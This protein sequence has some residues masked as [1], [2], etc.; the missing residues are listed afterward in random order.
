MAK[1]LMVIANTN[2]R[3]EELFHTKE[4]LEKAGHQTV[5]ASNSFS[6]A[7]GM[8][9][10]KIM[11]QILFKDANA[12]DYDAVVFVGGG[13]S[14][15]YFDN[16]KAHALA[17]E[18]FNQGKVTAAIC[19]A[20]STLANAGILKGKKATCYPS[21]KENLSAKGAKYT[22]TGVET[23]GKIITADGP[24]SAHEFGKKIAAA[25]K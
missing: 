24:K 22:A 4:E 5:I 18:F 11:P 8:L 12:G 23:D 19:I 3:D 25:L 1:V 7:T 21:E 10:G 2:F 9:G 16:P 13:G 6:E 20:P 14:A 15:I 17:R